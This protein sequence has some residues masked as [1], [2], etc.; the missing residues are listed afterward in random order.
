[1]REQFS[2]KIQWAIDNR[3]YYELEELWAFA[4]GVQRC[5]IEAAMKRLED[6]LEENGC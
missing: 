6:E 3:D 5:L 2:N 4:N 1:M